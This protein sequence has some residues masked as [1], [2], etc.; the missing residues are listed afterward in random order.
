M[1]VALI[2]FRLGHADGVSIE[3][4]KWKRALLKLGHHVFTVAGN[5]GVDRH[6]PG[7]DFNDSVEPDADAIRE[8]LADAEVV[9]VE[10]ICSLPLK[11]DASAC[12]VR[13]LR[14]RPA[15]LHHYDLPWQRERFVHFTGWPATDWAWRHVTINELS[16]DQLVRRGVDASVIPCAFDA[17]TTKG[18]GEELRA[19]L[20]I[21]PDAVLQLQPTRVIARKGIPSAIQLA[22]ALGAK[23]WITGPE[24]EGYVLDHE[25]LD[26]LRGWPEGEWT[27]NDAYAAC[28]VVSFPSLWEG[29]GMPVI[30]SAL[31]RKPL[32]VRHYPV[33]AEMARHGFRWFDVDRP[34]VAG[35]IRSFIAARH[36]SWTTDWLDHN[37]R[38]AMNEYSFDALGIRLRT[39]LDDVLGVRR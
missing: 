38:V 26:I 6:V 12:I 18:R 22:R 20:R 36:E 16:R 9:I 35:D 11:P 15:I 5:A 14:D 3:A 33:L 10:N 1:K 28:D 39:L 2:S 29:F 27:M 31:H 32:A 4:E 24:E 17:P 37:A 34:E 23:L 30:E 19:A 13:V 8:A 7:L 21:L 25:G